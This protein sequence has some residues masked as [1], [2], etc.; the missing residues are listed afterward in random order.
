MVGCNGSASGSV[1]A[2]VFLVLVLVVVVGFSARASDSDSAGVCCGTR[3]GRFPDEK[4][5]EVGC[6][7][8]PTYIRWWRWW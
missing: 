1:D 2:R 7:S 6:R 8:A 4:E 5:E 3:L